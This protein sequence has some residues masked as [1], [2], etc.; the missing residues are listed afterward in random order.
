MEV[1]EGLVGILVSVSFFAAILLSLYFYFRARTQEHLAMIEKGF[2]PKESVSKANGSL[3][4]LKTGILLMG[5][6]L[7]TFFG[8][9]VAK[10]TIVNGV[11]AYFMMILLLGGI[12]LIFTYYIESKIRSQKN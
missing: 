5:V 7:G 12:A 10:F 4:S 9:L 2:N 1:L 8:Y 11:I 6:A 3:R